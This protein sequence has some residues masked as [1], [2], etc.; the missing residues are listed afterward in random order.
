MADDAPA[1]DAQNDLRAKI[2]AIM[3]DTTMNEDEKARARQALMM[4][5]WGPKAP[6]AG[7]N[8]DAKGGWGPF[9]GVCSGGGNFK[10]VAKGGGGA[11]HGGWTDGGH[12][13]MAG[14][15]WAA[16]PAFKVRHGGWG[17]GPPAPAAAAGHARHTP[18][19][20]TS[21]CRM[22]GGGDGCRQGRDQAGGGV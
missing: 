7:E 14:C 20:V 4:G 22:R 21:A 5:G 1:N 18:A 16:W 17:N 8:G 11:E 3:R 19:R 10:N 9:G 2:M 12:G 13:S 6:A 15:N